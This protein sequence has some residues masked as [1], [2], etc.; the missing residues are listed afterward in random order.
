MKCK[1]LLKGLMVMGILVGI[2]A[3]VITRADTG[4]A[5]DESRNIK[6]KSLDDFST[7]SVDLEWGDLQFE[8]VYE[9][10][11]WRWRSLPNNNDLKKDSSYVRVV[12]RSNFPLEA[13]LRFIPMIEG[14][15]IS[16]D[17][18]G[19]KE[20]VGTCVD[21]TDKILYSNAWSTNKQDGLYEFKSDPMETVI[22]SDSNCRAQ[23]P[24]GTQYDASKTYYYVKLES[25]FYGVAETDN[26]YSTII[27]GVDKTGTV[28]VVGSQYNPTRLANMTEIGIGLFGGNYSTIRNVYNTT[29]T[30]GTLDIWLYSGD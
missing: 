29:K 25:E 28:N 9:N 2:T 17:A 10:N 14:L 22:Y 3:P 18:S 13:T 1:K 6:I 15:E 23:V 12:N 19:L 24:D 20:G 5:P 26:Y 16:Y 30:I 27:P 11:N 7:V 21:A 4:P 8:Y